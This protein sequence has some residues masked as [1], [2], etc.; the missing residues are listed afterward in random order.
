MAEAMIYRVNGDI[1]TVQVTEPMVSFDEIKTLMKWSPHTMVEVVYM[2]TTVMLIDEEGKLRAD[3]EQSRM[4][5]SASYMALPYIGA[6]DYI[7]GDAM[8]ITRA[9]MESGD[10][11]EEDNG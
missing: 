11:L 8:V 5:I 9:T 6:G 2:G 10:D 3:P 4:N 1:E 7:A